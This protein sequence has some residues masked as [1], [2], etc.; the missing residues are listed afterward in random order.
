MIKKCPIKVKQF[1][2]V[3]IYIMRCERKDAYNIPLLIILHTLK[4]T[5]Y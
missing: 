1:L 3:I 5:I 4:S 2:Q